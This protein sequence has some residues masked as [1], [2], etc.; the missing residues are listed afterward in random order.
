[1]DARA[2]PRRHSGRLALIAGLIAAVYPS[3]LMASISYM[4]EAFFCFYFALALLLMARFLID[5]RWRDLLLS[6]AVLALATLSRAVTLPLPFPLALLIIRR[7]K[8][9]QVKLLTYLMIAFL[10]IGVLTFRNWVY[11]GIASPS[12][13]S[14]WMLLFMRAASS[15]RRVT[16][17]DPTAIYARYVREIEQRL[18]NPE[19]QNIPANSILSYFQPTP[20][21]HSVISQMAIEKNLKYP[22]WYILN[23]FYGLYLVLFRSDFIAIS[24]LVL[25]PFHLIFVAL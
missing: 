21:M 17:E 23:G 4:T 6:A 10:P 2:G 19:A 14:A 3:M 5:S 15:E 16:D 20:A 24:P 25:L 7:S 22:V 18:G 12:T 13:E 8:A 9:W 1:G 11:D